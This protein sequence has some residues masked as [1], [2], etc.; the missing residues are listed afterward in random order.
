MKKVR[1]TVF[2]PAGVCSCSQSSFLS[3]VYAAVQKH[4]DLVEYREA[5]AES[6]EA[7][8]VGISYRGVLVGNRVLQMNPTTDMIDAAILEQLQIMNERD[9][10]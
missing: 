2:L 6:E 9:S 5:S 3:R 7:K 1:V 10:V 8:S 4:W